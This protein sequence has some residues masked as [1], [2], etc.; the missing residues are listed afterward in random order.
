M[1]KERKIANDE[2]EVMRE[3]IKEKEVLKKAELKALDEKVK[4]A[5]IAEMKREDEL[6][7]K[8]E[9]AQ[10][11]IQFRKPQQR[12]KTSNIPFQTNTNTTLTQSVRK[13]PVAEQMANCIIGSDYFK[14]LVKKDPYLKNLFG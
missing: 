4:A 1:E 10:K 2:I 12:H 14:G 6:K 5:R 8:N 11:P 7:R 9:L 3:R 13:S